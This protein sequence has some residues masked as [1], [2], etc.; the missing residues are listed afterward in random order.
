MRIR[1][2]F[3]PAFLFAFLFCSTAALAAGLE[4][5]KGQSGV[6]NIAGGTAHIPVMMEAAKRI[7][8]FNDKIDIT[9]T[10][11]GSG[12]GVRQVGEGLVNIG[13]TGRALKDSEIKQ[14]G[15]ISY[16]FAID[17][18]AVAVHSSNKVSDLN[19]EQ[20]QKLFS[21][22]IS[23]WKELGGDDVPVTLYTREDGSGTRE[24]FVDVLLNQEAIDPKAVIVNSNGSMKISI[25]KDKGAAGYV[26]IGHVDDSIK[27][28]KIEGVEPSQEN[29]AN[30]AYKVTR[31]LYMNT[32]GQPDKLT[33]T[34][35]EYITGSA[36]GR[37]LIEAAGYI[38]YSG[39]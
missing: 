31:L 14:Y 2:T 10:G 4:D 6:I 37:S 22:Q 26:G 8:Q 25:S 19:P 27:A 20:A 3:C 24:V 17:G 15:L 30:G 32:K 7:M 29:A 28:L 18:V 36:E 13:N 35:I 12:A 9:V 39:K 5:F 21:G 23:N 34:F 33:A 38:P 11:G 16:P 1:K